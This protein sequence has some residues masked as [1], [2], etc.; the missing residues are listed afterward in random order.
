MITAGRFTYRAH[1]S[2]DGTGWWSISVDGVRTGANTKVQGV[3]NV[4]ESARAVIA[5]VLDVPA[6][7][8]DVVVEFGNTGPVARN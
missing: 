8:F 3:D 6:D 2:A 1:A 5:L 4:N 7:S